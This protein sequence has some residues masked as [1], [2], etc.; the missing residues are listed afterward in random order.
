MAE[1]RARQRSS[2]LP[3]FAT[4]QKI[5]AGLM[6]IPLVLGVL[7]NTFA[8]GAL[9]IGSF[10]TASFEDGALALIALLIFATGAQITGSNSRKAA[11]TTTV[12]VLASDPR[13]LPFVPSAAAQTASAV[14][15]TAVL[16]PLVASW[17]LRWSGGP[18]V[19]DA[20][21]G[22]TSR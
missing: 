9:T 16:A 17:V 2:R 20:V 6:L 3:V 7:V 5:P 13:F 11:A 21:A 19:H 8:P 15:V 1:T 12:V 18:A 22:P 10:T 4:I 14:L